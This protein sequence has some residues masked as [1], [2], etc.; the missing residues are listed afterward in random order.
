MSRRSKRRYRQVA[1]TRVGAGQVQRTTE[2]DYREGPYWLPIT[3]GWLS[4]QAGQYLNWWQMGYDPVR[5]GTTAMVE[6]CASAYS[7][8]IAMCPGGHWRLNDDGG[9]ELVKN[10][11][12]ARIL[13]RPNDYQT[14]SDY[15]LNI[16]RSLYLAGNSYS[17]ALRND[18]FEVASLH[19]MH[20]HHSKPLVAEDG[21]VFYELG[22][23]EIIARR[24]GFEKIIVPARDVLHV[25]LH[26]PVHPLKG[27]TPIM[28]AAM[29]IAASG[30]MT[31]QQYRFFVNQ[32][33][34]SYVLG[35]EAVL[36]KEQVDELRVRWNEQ[37]Q[38]LNSGG[39]PILTAGL[40]PHP[41]S[42]S[43][44]DAS[45]ADMLKMGDEHIALAFRIPLQIL[46][47]GGT[48]FAST[49]LLMQSWIASGF[50][51]ALNHLEEALGILFGLKG[52]PDEYLELS[53][54]SLLRSAFKERVE[55]LSIGTKS[56]L[57]APNEGRRELELPEAA[58]GDEPR[59]QQQDVPLSYGAQ[60]VPPLPPPPP[61]PE[62]TDP[63]SDPGGDNDPQEEQVDATEW[64][65]RIV[66][67][68]DQYDRD[69]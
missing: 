42:V 24:S 56:G 30:A 54:A 26:T 57:I 1:T 45:L 47:L 62:P 41:L 32:A 6:A 49:E 8:T 31:E 28:A 7:Q 38:G 19:M 51:F 66:E 39:T 17:L 60:Q 43:A 64:A 13:R 23:N 27:E 25:R 4:Q 9:R 5:G 2:G 18:R 3:G 20:P 50:G 52:Q 16:T 69:P 48:P 46:G 58:F 35:T 61:P 22:G 10:S 37:S 53:T 11:A 34:P 67:A 33:R 40:K 15:L 55:A 14:I 36:T 65:R 29:D 12:L 21:E 59:M 68:A 44:K 63:S